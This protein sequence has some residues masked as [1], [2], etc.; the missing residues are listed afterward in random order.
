VLGLVTFKFTEASALGFAIPLY[1]QELTRKSFVP[2]TRRAG[3]PKRAAELMKIADK[4]A[5]LGQ[6]ALRREGADGETHKILD[7]YAAICYRTALTYDPANADLYYNI[8]ML[9]RSM[10][11][12]DAATGYLLRG[13]QLK[14][15]G[16]KT[17]GE[18][19]AN[20]YRELGFALVKQKKDALALTAWGEGVSK[21]PYAAKVWEDLAI[22]Y[23]QHDRPADAAE[24]A[25]ITIL[26]ADRG[27]R[28]SVMESLTRDARA[29]AARQGQRAAA[30][31]DARVQRKAM[32]A[33]LDKLLTAS[34]AARR[35]RK[36]YVSDAFVKLVKEIGGPAV[37]GAEQTIPQQPRERLAELGEAGA[38][39]ASTA[40]PNPGAAAK[41]TKPANGNGWLG[42]ADDPKKPGAPNKAA[43]DTG[44]GWIG[45]DT[46]TATRAQGTKPAAVNQP[47]AGKPKTI[48]DAEVTPI[49]VKDVVGAVW[50]KD[51]KAVV[52]LQKDGL[53]RRVRLPDFVEERQVRIDSP[54]GSLSASKEG[55]VAAV[56]GLQELWLFDE[57]T[58]DLKRHVTAP[59]VG[60]AVSGPGSNIAIA[61][62]GSGGITII[63]LATGQTL[64]QLTARDLQEQRGPGARANLRFNLFA[65]SPDGKYFFTEGDE[66]IHRLRVEGKRLIYE[67]GGPRIGSNPQALIVSPD[68][69]YVCLPSGGGNGRQNGTPYNTFV[70]PVTDLQKPVIVISSGAYPR[71]L[72]FDVAARQLYAQNFQTQ[73]MVYSP[74]GLKGKEYAIRDAG[75]PRTLLVHPA[76]KQILFIGGPVYWIELP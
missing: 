76:G 12:D 41:S 50:T 10:D 38:A 45:S 73:L 13:I 6:E 68:G 55:L 46:A 64:N 19:N 52:F 14:P 8:G 39:P 3:D 23:I 18:G 43:P 26:L 15:W 65:M 35:A 54:C 72:G 66:C 47:L 61:N 7:A 75:E 33:K 56:T 31:L 24:A 74:T 40:V 44:G 32:V 63:N 30:D 62:T 28:V 59:S 9:L 57:T 21:F 25:Q 11:E 37:E 27:T 48:V 22:H 60:R 69:R 34:N 58:L 5:D 67:E 53:L 36:L 42:G 16:N 51:A 49:D 71:T 20:A 70:Y 1:D 29:A 2:P 4:Y 17:A